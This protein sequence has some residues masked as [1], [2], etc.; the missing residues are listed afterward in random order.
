MD[1]SAAVTLWGVQVSA[2]EGQI[3]PAVILGHMVVVVAPA[4]RLRARPRMRA[5]AQERSWT[6]TTPSSGQISCAQQRGLVIVHGLVAL[7]LW[8][9]ALAIII[10][11]IGLGSLRVLVIALRVI[12]VSII[13][14]MIVGLATVTVVLVALM[15]VMIFPT[16]ML[17]VAWFTATRGR[18][19]SRFLFLWLLLVLSNLL[20]N[21]SHLVGCLTLL[22][23]RWA[24]LDP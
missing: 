16:K 14:I 24:W 3:W 5:R 23:E 18:K 7:F 2:L 15:V 9:I 21:A 12:A 17:Q 1:T 22:K 13:L 19:M 10:L 6:R 4:A 20:E 11:V 8:V